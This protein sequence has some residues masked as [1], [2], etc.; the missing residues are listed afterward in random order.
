MK[1]ETRNEYI[2]RT[3]FMDWK[4]YGDELHPHPQ[5]EQKVNSD[6][7]YKPFWGDTMLFYLNQ[8]AVEVLS[9]A[10]R[11]LHESGIPLSDRLNPKQFHITLH[12]LDHT[13]GC[14]KRP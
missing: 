1:I 6:G 10:Q 8:D 2:E 5:V 12:D 9:V 4:P 7:S 3:A 14:D 13:M 11:K